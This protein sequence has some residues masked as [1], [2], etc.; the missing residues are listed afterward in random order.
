MSRELDFLKGREGEAG[1]FY[2]NFKFRP[3][4]FSEI[5]REEVAEMMGGP[6]LNSEEEDWE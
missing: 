6:A 4:D 1:K 2:I 5:P 3:V